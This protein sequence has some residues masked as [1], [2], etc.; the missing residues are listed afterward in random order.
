LSIHA[1]HTLRKDLK[2]AL[3]KY[4]VILH[5]KSREIAIKIKKRQDALWRVW[6]GKNFL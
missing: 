6:K 4:L 2:T 3:R 1:S 5:H